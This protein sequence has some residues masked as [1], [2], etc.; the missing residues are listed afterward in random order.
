MLD[1][2]RPAR[3]EELAIDL[4]SRTLTFRSPQEFEAALRPRTQV[5][6]DTLRKLARLDDDNLKL[7]LRETGAV[8]KRLLTSL[9]RT[10]ETGEDV[11]FIWR[12]IDLGRIYDEQQW[13]MLIFALG[14]EE[15]VADAY[16]RVAIVKY[17]EYLNARREALGQVMRDR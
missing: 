12:E 4:E 13:Q 6:A 9:L 17:L 15:S 2:V 1:R 10:F 11:L 14:D 16:R 5:T 8:H 3:R 7:E